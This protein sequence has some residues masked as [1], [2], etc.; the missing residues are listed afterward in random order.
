MAC[1]E[2]MP[3]VAAM[4]GLVAGLKFRRWRLAAGTIGVSAVWF[5]VAVMIIPPYFAPG[6]N[7][8]LDRYAWLGDFPVGMIQTVVTQPGL[9]VEHLWHQADLPGYL[10]WLFFPVTFLALFSPVT[11]LPMAPI[12]AVNLLSDNPF[13]WRL[14]D[15]HYGAPLAPFLMISTIDGV[16]RILRWVE[17]NNGQWSTVNGQRSMKSPS[18]SQSPNLLISQ[19]LFC[20]LL[21][22]FSLIYHY[23]R[24]FSPLARPFSWPE[25]TAHHRQLA[26]VLAT[27]PPE[28]AVFTPS[29]LAPHL[30]QRQTIY[31]E[32]AYFTD[33]DFPAQTPVEAVIL[34]VTGFENIGGLHQFLRERLL[35][36]GDYE[37]VTALSGI[38][39]LKPTAEPVSAVRLPPP[40]FDFARPTAPAKYNLRVDFGDRFRLHGYTL[41]FNRQEEIEVS[42]DLE[43][44]RPL[45]GEQPVL[46]LLDETG[47]PLG[48]TTDLQPGL[49]WYPAARWPVGE[50]VRLRFDTL[51][52]HTRTTARYRLAV[53]VIEG[54]DPWD[55]GRRL[56][57]QIVESPFA[58]RLPAEGTLVE[59]ARIEQQW[60]MPTG[61]AVAR[62]ESAPVLPHRLEVDFGDQVRL[63]GH[64]DIQLTTTRP[65]ELSVT[66]AWQA[67]RGPEPLVRFVQV[68][69]PD[70]Q[71]YGQRDSAPDRGQ[72]PTQVWQRGEVVIDPVVFPLNPTRPDGDYTLHIGLYR[73]ETGQRLI[74]ASGADHLEIRPE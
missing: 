25:V 11:L 21:L 13:Q 39:Y 55:V 40:F 10:A 54:D 15:F 8:Q 48:A 56:L 60:Q 38:L 1:K 50:R 46:Y 42:L 63:L 6:G 47:T 22:T 29:N 37:L 69:G 9:V 3:L 72:Y 35:E 32:F 71:V 43:P 19:L 33:P 44:L 64:S 4:V 65:D 31:T 49:V 5:V 74:L 17:R 27:V 28:A 73:P 12:L 14:E 62:L 67:L 68:I 53:G 30:S 16:R 7:I 2:D 52:W 59:L 36:S 66:L 70:G 23:Q 24:G 51:P 20:T 41:H 61:G 34:E 57:A 26:E 45:A 58:T 18:I